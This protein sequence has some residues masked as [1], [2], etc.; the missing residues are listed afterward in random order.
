MRTPVWTVATTGGAVAT[1]GNDS[2]KSRVTASKMLSC[3]YCSNDDIVLD[4][5]DSPL[6]AVNVY[7]HRDK[8]V[9][10]TA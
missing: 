8:L 5:N 4:D 2:R 6:F 9:W 7:N 3:C 1:R 10:P